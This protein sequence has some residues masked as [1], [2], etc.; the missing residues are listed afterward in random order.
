MIYYTADQHFGHANIIKHCNRPFETVDEMDAYLLEQWNSCVRP[1]DTIY[2]LGD[3][4][5]RNVVPADAYL[6]KL[7]GK[8]HL[9]QGNHDKD[10]MKKTDLKWHFES[11]SNM[12]E[13][14]DGS[15]KMTLC[16]YPMMT[17]NGVANGRYHVYAHIHNNTDA[18]YFQ[19]LKE[20]PN[21]LNAGVDING[22]KPVTFA[23]LIDNN[24]RFKECI[25]KH[26]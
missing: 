10:W 2:I 7:H 17:W 23:E 8:K 14:N 16:H 19:L 22:F 5:F 20:M 18:A 26:D 24:I 12:L 1:N 3:L 4:F 6:S 21:A 25:D 13:M 15:Y 9:I 11:V